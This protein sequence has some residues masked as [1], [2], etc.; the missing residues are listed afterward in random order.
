MIDI[1]GDSQIR[2]SITGYKIYF[3]G[4]ALIWYSWRQPLIVLSER[5]SFTE[6]EYV[7]IAECC[8]ELLYLK[9]LLK[10]NK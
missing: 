7:T 8:K 3:E 6:A 1:T 5:V 10:D 2:R 4:G 9:T